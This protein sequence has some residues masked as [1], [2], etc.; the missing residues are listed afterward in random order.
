ME[1]LLFDECLIEQSF[2]F[3]STLKVQVVAFDF[4]FDLNQKP[5]IVEISYGYAIEGYELCVG[6][7][8][9]TLIFH[10]GKF[11]SCEWMVDLVLKQINEKKY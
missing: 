6:Y 8:D 4:V 11:D 5:L 1:K 3:A 9:K 2:T 7:W 10:K